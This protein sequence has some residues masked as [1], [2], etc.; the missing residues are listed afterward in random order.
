MPERWKEVHRRA[1][2]GETLRA[3]EDRW[4]GQ[5][6][7]HWARWEVRPWKT[8]EGT[9]GGILILAEDITRRKRI[10]EM[11]SG[12]SRK[13]IEAQ[14]E[15]RIRIGRELHDDINQRLALLAVELEQLQADPSEMQTRLQELRKQATELSNDVQALS[16][17]LHSSKLEYLGVVSGI[18][19]WCKEF[20]E[21]QAMEIDFKSD[22]STV[23]P[24]DV[25][26][27]LFRVLQESLHNSL[28]HSG[29]K[30]V[31]VRLTEHSKEFHL[32]VTD[33]GRGFDVEAA[34]RGQ[35]LGLTSMR[36]RVRLVNGTITIESKPMGG[37]TIHV[38][39]PVESEQRAQSAAG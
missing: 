28:K 23:V 5:D 26:I 12:M 31:E 38:R 17:E 11:L 39:V 29:E 36:E 27:C 30:R 14:E 35:G 3:D 25:G 13:L 34:I 33:Y 24:L 37:T 2:N 10:E 8:P 21:R 22:V 7:P 4:E 32:I 1:L 6:G 19:S 16:H 18:K 15:E 9:V 20:G